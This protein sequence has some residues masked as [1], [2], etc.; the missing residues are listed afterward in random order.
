MQVRVLVRVLAVALAVPTAAIGQPAEPEGEPPPPAEAEAQPE[1]ELT[2]RLQAPLL[3]GE[4]EEEPELGPEE[5]RERLLS[6]EEPAQPEQAAEQEEEVDEG[7]FATK[8]LPLFALHGY[9]RTRFELFQDFHLGRT[10]AS[11]PY[12]RPIESICY[13]DADCRDRVGPVGNNNRSSL[14]GGNLRLRFEPQINV[15][16]EVQVNSRIDVLDN[17]VLGSTPDGY[18]TGAGGRNP[19]VPIE[20]FT[21]TQV[22]PDERNSYTDSVA[23]K[24]AWAQVRTSLGVLRFGRMGSQWG[25]GVLANGGNDIDS[26]YGDV[27]DR[28]LFATRIAGVT[29]VPIWDFASE[30]MIVNDPVQYQ[31]Q[32]HDAG[33]LDDVN[34]Y[35]LVL[36]RKLDEEDF[37]N[38]M[39]LGLPTL[40]GGAY[41]V[42]REQILTSELH[43]LDTGFDTVTDY[44]VRRSAEAFIP[45]LWVRFDYRKLRL[46][47]ETVWITGTIANTSRTELQQDDYEISQLG[48]AFQLEYRLLADKLMLA[49][50]TGYA[51][52]D[53]DIEGL[54][55]NDGLLTQTNDSTVSAFRFDRDY[56]VDLIFWRNL[57]GAFTSAYYFK[58]SISYDFINNPFGQLFGGRLDI[59]WSRATDFVQTRGNHSDLALEFDVSFYYR[60]EDGTTREDGF[61]AGLQYGLM[62]PLAGMYNQDNEEARGEIADL[63]NAQTVRAIL[64]VVY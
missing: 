12:H 51:S 64:G 37:E 62:I 40:Q 20:A 10:D 59:L 41:L 61:V 55:P 63:P 13:D 3:Q 21:S 42:Y 19:W 46:E 1:A 8:T 47:L 7:D 16:D 17:L 14:A 33:Q 58:P 32:P 53:Q 57:V 34:Q 49:F 15:S 43:N 18:A 45:D 11:A 23:V 4:G 22:P 27:A 48:G 60:S 31:G 2:P 44:V 30:G 29:V 35:I 54:S 52:G 28:I 9:F 24:H 56:Y 50:E 36:A 39:Q 25:L 5:A 26:N 38:R 6:V